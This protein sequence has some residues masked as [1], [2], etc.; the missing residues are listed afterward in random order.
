MRPLPAHEA[1]QLLEA[2]WEDRL[3]ALYV[4]AIHT[5]MRRGEVLGPKWADVD[6][7]NATIRVQRTLTRKDTGYV[8]GN[9]RTK[10]S[11]RSVRLTQRAIEAL[12]S[13]RAQQA[14]GNLKS[15]SLYQDQKIVFAGESGGLINPSNLRQRFFTPLLE[16]EE[17]PHIT[18]H[19]LRHT[20]ASLLFQRNVHPKIVQEPLR[21]ASVAITLDTYSHLLPG[22]GGEAATAM[23][24]VLP[25]GASTVMPTGTSS[26][27]ES[28]SPI[29]G[30]LAAGF[31]VTPGS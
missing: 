18:F 5:G 4:L 22:M 25:Q 30:R 1:Q 6:L 17:L 14:E 12:R 27:R 2:A 26:V 20:C 24:D 28:A 11:R 29:Y 16:R 3:E 19:D 21:H 7:E 13:H 23:E 8:L 31:S 15:G 10:K 9:P